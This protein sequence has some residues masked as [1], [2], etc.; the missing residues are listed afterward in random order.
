MIGLPLTFAAACKT[1]FLGIPAWYR[2][3]QLDSKCQVTGLTVPGD[4]TL[5]A[6]AI[7]DALLRVAGL[8]AVLF[9]IFGGIQYATSQGSPDAT[10]RAQ[11]TVINAL[12]GMA[13]S[14]VAVAFVSYLGNKL[15]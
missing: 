13:L 4:L 8:V 7:V 12:A 10:A 2:Y 15:G 9:V 14:V 3:L 1:T 11:S 6:L 5:I